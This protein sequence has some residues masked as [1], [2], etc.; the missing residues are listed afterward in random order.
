MTTLLAKMSVRRIWQ[1]ESKAPFLVVTQKQQGF[2]FWVLFGGLSGSLYSIPKRPEIATKIATPRTLEGAFMT[3]W[4]GQLNLSC[5]GRQRLSEAQEQCVMSLQICSLQFVSVWWLTLVVYVY[6]K[7][8]CL[9]SQETLSPI[10][11]NPSLHLPLLLKKLIIEKKTIVKPFGCP[12]APR[13]AFK[14]KVV[15]AFAAAFG[16]RSCP[17][18]RA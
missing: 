13:T 16:H 18:R 11:T 14:A 1:S 5:Q 7:T 9:F 3:Q 10:I 15:A 17:S 2:R 4:F 12:R 8:L 6:S